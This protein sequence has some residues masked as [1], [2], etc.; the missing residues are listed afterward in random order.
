MA[1]HRLAAN[2]TQGMF[3]MPLDYAVAPDNLGNGEWIWI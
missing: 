3:T 1:N 2:R